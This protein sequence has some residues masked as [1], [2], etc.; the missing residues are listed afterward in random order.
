MRVV[1]FWFAMIGTAGIAILTVQIQISILSVRRHKCHQEQ[2][3][4]P[5]S[6]MPPPMLHPWVYR[7]RLYVAYDVSINF[8]F[9]GNLV[10]PQ[11]S[12]KGKGQFYRKIPTVL[13]FVRQFECSLLNLLCLS[14]WPNV[15][16]VVDSRP[17][18]TALFAK[19][20]STSYSMIWRGWKKPVCRTQ[21]LPRM[22]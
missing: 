6:K 1:D 5:R 11:E 7:T 15:L 22:I 18:P 19:K 12:K 14:N 9:V 3:K 20:I 16:L 8:T 17:Q 13:F 4:S 21:K 2:K 10:W